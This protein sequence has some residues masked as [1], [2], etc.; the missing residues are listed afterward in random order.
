MKKILRILE[1]EEEELNDFQKIL[2]LNKRKIS[3]SEVEFYN[4]EGEDFSDIITVEQ[5]GLMFTFDGLEEYLRFFFPEEHGDEGTDGYYEAGYYDSMYRG[6]WTWDFDDRSYDDWKE[7]IIVESLTPAHLQIIYDVAKII[8]PGLLKAFDK[9]EHTNQLTI[10]NPDMITGFLDQ[11]DGRISDDLIGRWVDASVSAVEGGVGE[12]IE[13][14]YCNCLRP[15]G[16]ENYSE[17]HCFWK[18]KLHWGDAIMLYPRFGTEEDNLLDLLF[19]AISKEPISHLP[20]YYEIQYNVW[21]NE[22]FN[23]SFNHNVDNDL[24]NF[25]SR[26]LEDSNDETLKKYYLVLD[27]IN[28]TIGFDKS[29]DIPNSNV[30]LNIK[31]V[32]KETLKVKYTLT[33]RKTYSTKYGESYINDIL[34][35]VYNESLF[36][37][38][39]YRKD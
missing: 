38:M 30:R 18:Y 7:G 9:K 3:P 29:V 4:F 37:P 12:Y 27:K 24:D 22:A 5:D 13:D 32:N 14:T 26:V 11:V 23:A 10:E 36:N 28:S 31:D 16:I 17:R 21:D 35:M 1:Q 19:L 15:V 39:E 8:Q 2:A 20:E 34:N 33:D 6:N 25:K